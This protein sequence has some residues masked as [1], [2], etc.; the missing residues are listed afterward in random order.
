[1]INN[2]IK[3]R[4]IN[5]FVEENMERTEVLAEVF[6]GN[7]YEAELYKETNEYFAKDYEGREFLVGELKIDYLETPKIKLGNEFE[8]IES[9]KINEAKDIDI[10]KV[11]KEREILCDGNCREEEFTTGLNVEFDLNKFK[12]I[13]IFIPGMIGIDECMIRKYIIDELGQIYNEIKYC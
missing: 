11:N 7:E 10:L 5:S 4:C 13:K 9:E 12:G 1:M 6:E 2:K 3:V 8:L